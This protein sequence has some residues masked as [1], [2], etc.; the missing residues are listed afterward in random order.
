MLKVLGLYAII[1]KSD[2]KFH[3]K[4]FDDL[5]CE[6]AHDDR[7]TLNPIS[8]DKQ[9]SRYFLIFFIFRSIIISN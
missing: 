6:N 3:F 1:K 8:K 7:N 9:I 5:W 2:I 4:Y